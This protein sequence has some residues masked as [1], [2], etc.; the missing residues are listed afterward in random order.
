ME[1]SSPQTWLSNNEGWLGS[2]Q[3]VH[4]RIVEILRFY[5]RSTYSALKER[6]YR[7]STKRLLSAGLKRKKPKNLYRTTWETQEQLCIWFVLL[8]LKSIWLQCDNS[9]LM[10]VLQVHLCLQPCVCGQSPV[11]V[12]H[13]LLALR[14]FAAAVSGKSHF[15]FM[16]TQNFWYSP[17]A[18]PQLWVWG[19]RQLN[20]AHAACMPRGKS[21]KPTTMRNKP[22]TNGF[23]A[24]LGY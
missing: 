19:D 3:M 17:L 16:S 9:A 4:T 10:L 1:A 24:T 18:T 23:S 13:C 5:G 14:F 21:L 20:W 7:F 12:S 6:G 11:E 8:P 15:I 22:T 2:I